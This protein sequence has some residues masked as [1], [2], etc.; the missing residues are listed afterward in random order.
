MTRW[1]RWA[2][3]LVGVFAVAFA[4]MLVFAFKK[5]PVVSTPAGGGGTYP[6]AVVET[7][8]GQS[9]KFKGG[10]EDVVVSYD[11]LLRYQDNSTRLLG[12]TISTK[13]RGGE[14]TF[15]VSGKEGFVGQDESTIT[16]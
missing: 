7:T 16:L 9:F 3:L 1:Q 12:V 15:I 6:N 5:R 8:S 4:P 2:R 10:R 11:K 14:R 13:E